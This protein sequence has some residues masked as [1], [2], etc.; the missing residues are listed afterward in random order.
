M[1]IASR[2]QQDIERRTKLIRAEFARM[3]TTALRENQ[4]NKQIG[5]CVM[6]SGLNPDGSWS[7]SNW[8]LQGWDTVVSAL[9]HFTSVYDYA[10][11]L[12]LTDEQAV[13]MAN[14]PANLCL[15]HTS[16]NSVKGPRCII[17]VVDDI[18]LGRISLS[19]PRVWTQQEIEEKRQRITAANQKLS[20][21]PNWRKN[22]AA[23][24]KK[25]SQ[26]PRWRASVAA[27]AKKQSQN[28]E[29]RA[30]MATVLKK[31]WQDPNYQKNHA[32]A[33]K[34]VSQDPNY[35]K[36]RAEANK[37]L[38]QDPNWIAANAA[39]TKKLSQDPNFRAAIKKRSQDPKWIAAQAAGARN[40]RETAPA[41][42]ASSRRRAVGRR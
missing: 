34:K 32:E 39:A 35:Q 19:K 28:P 2:S 14:D 1:K 23:G 3:D 33:M 21:D 25:R 15:L 20:R 7:P 36:N 42:P 5:R 8:E 24:I 40:G 16:C 11:R 6:C 41:P 30:T 37:K 31:R 13:A 18:E 26:D 22:Q 38:S 9:D 4:F 12:D 27:A 29:W 10:S 17:E